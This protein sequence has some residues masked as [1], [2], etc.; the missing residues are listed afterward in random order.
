MSKHPVPGI[1]LVVLPLLLLGACASGPA[2]DTS[3]VDRSLTP[4]VVSAQ[5]QHATGRQVLWGGTILG[6]TN[7][8]HSTLVEMQAYPLGYKE[9]PQTDEAPLGRFLLEQ[10]GFLEPAVYTG[11]R[12]L[13]VTGTITRID[14]GKVGKSEQSYPVVEAKQLHLWPVDSFRED[15]GLRFG[16]EI[17]VG[18]GF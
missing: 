12:L 4:A 3:Q 7:L 11:G 9:K 1:I 13:T 15:T 17:G 5:P 18:H 14:S 16:G 2:F 10:S 6:V 8:A